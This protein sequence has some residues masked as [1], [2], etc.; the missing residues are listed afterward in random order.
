MFASANIQ[1][2]RER[3][4]PGTERHHVRLPAPATAGQSQRG[5]GEQSRATQ[6]HNA[7]DALA[8]FL[9]FPSEDKRQEE[10]PPL[11]YTFH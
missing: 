9:L 10:G 7:E 11:L 2:W 3:T 8:S 6:V 5:V 1:L 4:L